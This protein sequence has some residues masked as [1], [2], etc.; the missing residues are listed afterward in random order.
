MTIDMEYT[1]ETENKD[2]ELAREVVAKLRE[3]L[4]YNQ[5]EGNYFVHL[6]TLDDLRAALDLL[7]RYAPGGGR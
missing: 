6:V 7:E 2:R 1:V 4:D 3:A 5:T